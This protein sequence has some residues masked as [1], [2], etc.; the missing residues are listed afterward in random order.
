MSQSPVSFLETVVSW[1]GTQCQVNLDTALPRLIRCFQEVNVVQ[2]QIGILKIICHSFLPCVEAI[3][4]EEKLFSKLIDEVCGVFDK[5]L[6]EIH[7]Y[8]QNTDK[9]SSIPEINTNLQVLLDLLEFMETCLCHMQNGNVALNWSHIHS[10]PRGTVHFLKGAYGHCMDSGDIYQDLLSSLSAP[11]STLFKKTHSLQVAFLRLLDNIKLSDPVTEQDVLDLTQVCHGLFDVC[12]IV[13]SL[14]MKLMVT[15]WKAISKHAINNKVHVGQRLEVGEMIGHLCGE[16]QSGFLFLLQLIP[17]VDPEGVV[18]SQGDEKGFQKSL[19][20]LGF[21]MKILVMLVREFS[22]IIHGCEEPVYG[23]LLTLMRLL[24]PS[25]SSQQI[26]EKHLKDIRQHL[27]NA[28]DVLI[29]ALLYNKTFTESVTGTE[30]VSSLT[31]EDSF[32]HLQMVLKVLEILPQLSDEVQDQ[33]VDPRLYPEDEDRLSVIDVV[34]RTISNCSKEL[35]LPII[36]TDP[37]LTGKPERDITLY[38]GCCTRLCG[39]L[40]SLSAKHFLRAEGILFENV[41]SHDPWC[42]LLAED[43]WCFIIRYGSADLCRDHVTFLLEVIKQCW[44]FDHESPLLSLVAR[45]IKCLSSDHQTELI[46]KLSSE[47]DLS[48][49]YILSC[50]LPSLSDENN[51]NLVDKVTEKCSKTLQEFSVASEKTQQD[52]YRMLNAVS[53]LYEILDKSDTMGYSVQSTV[54]ESITDGVSQLWRNMFISDWTDSSLFELC[55]Q[56]LVLLSSHLSSLLDNDVLL[57]ILS[58]SSSLLQQGCT[59]HLHLTIVC[60]LK[61]FGKIRPTATPEQSQILKKLSDLFGMTLTSPDLFI[62][63]HGLS[64]FTQFAENTIHESVVPDCIDQQ[65]QLQDFVVQFLSKMPYTCEE[66]SR[67]EFLREGTIH[68]SY[69]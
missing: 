51:Q 35:N 5:A 58:V 61:S 68:K 29:K 13:T 34:F 57:K 50:C 4:A 42:R 10:L 16:I 45:L 20:I 3:Q 21:Q 23:L 63:H 40:G 53:C 64:A 55:L 43:V 6:D 28:T 52:C 38:E 24:P 19:K 66:L 41:C 2:E 8:T 26:D 60:F 59:N 62:H 32:P 14:D 39:F 31:D 12:Q 11:L 1:D 67:L 48:T 7:Q 46:R 54:T 27:T 47:D 44:S 33:W 65:P 9:K 17:G 37:V 15:L 69:C 25:L 22:D 30:K 49:L 56:R 18:L 36:L